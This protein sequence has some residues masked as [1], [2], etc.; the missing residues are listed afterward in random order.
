[1]AVGTRILQ[2]SAFSVR[3]IR[4]NLPVLRPQ[5]PLR[6]GLSSRKSA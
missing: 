3:E 6:A 2:V 5:G 4:D 1:M